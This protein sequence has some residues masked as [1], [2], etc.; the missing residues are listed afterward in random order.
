MRH[1]LVYGDSNSHGSAPLPDLQTRGRY[2]PTE[3]WPGVMA[4]A[5][6][7]GWTVIEEAL[8]GRTT[9]HPDPVSGLHKNGLMVLPA[10]L[11]SHAPLDLVILM[12]GTNDLKARFNVPPV[13]VAE[14]VAHLVRLVGQSAAG[15]DGGPPRVM[16]IAPPAVDEAGC[17][18]EIFQG[19]TEKSRRLGP[20]YADIAARHGAAFLDAGALIAPSPVDGVHLAVQDHAKLGAAVADAVLAMEFDGEENNAQR[21]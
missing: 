13:E 10:V 21:D 4:A 15:P 11:E 1:V 7:D 14:G 19:A 6:G 2:G 5:L 8:P 12:L 9:V 20:H 18:A 17:L 3:R 16:L